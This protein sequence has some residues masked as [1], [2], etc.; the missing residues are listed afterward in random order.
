MGYKH[1]IDGFTLENCDVKGNKVFNSGGI[2]AT[3][4]GSDNVFK[5]INIKDKIRKVTM[6][7]DKQ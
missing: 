2:T 5:N 1:E 7:S 4:F 3:I 6:L